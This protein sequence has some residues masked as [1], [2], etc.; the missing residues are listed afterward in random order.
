MWHFTDLELVRQ[1]AKGSGG[2]EMS[3]QA[4]CGP[5]TKQA[6]KVKSQ[7]LSKP[8]NERFILQILV[9]F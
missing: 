8:F 2:E 4:V 9:K 1:V 6:G 7:A 5:E 3:E